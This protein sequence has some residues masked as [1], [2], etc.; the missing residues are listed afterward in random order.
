MANVTA[1]QFQQDV[2]NTADWANGDENTTVTMRLGQQADSPAKVIKRVDDLAAAQREDIYENATPYT[3][4]NFTDGFT[5]TALNQRGEFG[6]DQYVFLGGLAGLPHV[7]A[8]ATDPTLSPSLYAKANYNDAASVANANGGNVQNQLDIKDGLTVTEAI[9]YAGI[10]SLVGSRVWITD[11]KAW[12]EIVLT[13]S[14][15]ISPDGYGYIQFLTDID[16]SMKYSLGQKITAVGFGYVSG[17]STDQSGPVQAALNFANTAGAATKVQLPKGDGAFNVYI[18]NSGIELV[19]RGIATTRVKPFSDAPCISVAPEGDSGINNYQFGG[20]SIKNM[21]IVGDDLGRDGRHGIYI[22]TPD[23]GTG[24]DSEVVTINDLTL[25]NLDIR[26]CSKGIVVRAKPDQDTGLDRVVQGM[27]F[28]NVVCQQNASSGLYIEGH[29]IESQFYGFRCENNGS[30]TSAGAG[31]T[32]T[33]KNH[34]NFVCKA[35]ETTASPTSINDYIFPGRLSFNGTVLTEAAKGNHEG[36]TAYITG[37]REINFDVLDMENCFSCFELDRYVAGGDTSNAQTVW[38]V[39]VNHVNVQGSGDPSQ[40]YLREFAKLN[41]CRK[42]SYGNIHAYNIDAST[43]GVHVIPTTYFNVNRVIDLGGNSFGSGKG[44]LDNRSQTLATGALDVYQDNEYLVLPS[45][46]SQIQTLNFIDASYSPSHNS[47]ITIKNRSLTIPIYIRKDVISGAPTPV[48][49]KSDIVLLGRKDSITLKYNAFTEEF[50]EVG[51][52]I[53]P[54]ETQT[55]DATLANLW[56]Y[57]IRDA[58]VVSVKA[59]VTASQSDLSNSATYEITG[60]FRRNGGAAIKES[61]VK[62]VE[63]ETN[64][65]WNADL[66]V[67]GNEIR[68]QVTGAAATTIDW[69]GNVKVYSL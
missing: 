42:F 40:T 65:A 13:S 12:F 20:Q 16:Y 14:L 62:P 44:V 32:V 31:A 3:V 50:D 4:G 11:R 54:R 36:L 46:S 56:A 7:V 6:G 59:T 1:P 29:V 15:P 25:E 67:V 49:I 69:H 39:S 57:E 33:E 41:A 38:S 53:F 30:T 34:S 51:R 9:N 19:G 24:N 47:V 48:N 64:A 58:T 35:I 37:G 60:L 22:S 45:A 27:Q 5:Y 63:I 17:L 21:T 28:R 43:I 23:A 2:N 55:T 10:A 52:C 8:P 18:P 61:S 66:N 26:Q 68:L